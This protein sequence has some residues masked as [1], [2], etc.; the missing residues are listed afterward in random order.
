MQKYLYCALLV[1]SFCTLVMVLPAHAEDHSR[2]ASVQDIPDALLAP[3]FPSKIRLIA[4]PEKTLVKKDFGLE[5]YTAHVLKVMQASIPAQGALSQKTLGLLQKKRD[6]YYTTQQLGQV[7]YYDANMDGK[8]TEAEIRDVYL[9]EF[10]PENEEALLKEAVPVA[11]MLKYDHDKDGVISIAELRVL[12][13]P[14]EDEAHFLLLKSLLPLD[15]D[16]DAILTFEEL[17]ALAGKAFRTMDKDGDGIVSL[18][19]RPAERKSLVPL[20]QDK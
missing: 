13:I 10:A 4:E 20:A 5:E 16:G 18:S 11:M 7:L 8:V 2:Y 15:P 19:E 9:R 14:A 1:L 17:K 12:M 6:K 3:L